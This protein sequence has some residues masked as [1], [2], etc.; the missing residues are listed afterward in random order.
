MNKEDKILAIL[1][2][3]QANMTAM[4]ADIG[5]IKERLGLVEDHTRSLRASYA[6]IENEQYPKIQ[7]SLEGIL[8]V[9]D[10]NYVQDDRI[11]YLERKTDNH[12]IRLI[13]LE[14]KNNLL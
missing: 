8:G 11:S 3:V 5:D 13:V 1:E 6:S 7:I 2:Q 12:H 10:K 9:V 14:E 4:Q